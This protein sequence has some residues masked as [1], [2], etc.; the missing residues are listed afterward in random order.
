MENTNIIKRIPEEKKAE[1]FDKIAEMFFDKNFGTTT[2]SE[3]ELLMFSILMDEMIEKHKGEDNTLDYSA[4][5]DYKIGKMLG[6]TQEKVRSLKIKKQARYPVEFDWSKSLLSIKDNIVYDEPKKKII[7]PMPDPNLYNE[8]RNFVEEQGR[9][10]E[11]QRGQNCLQMRPEYLFMI[12]YYQIDDENK[13]AKVR[14]NFAKELRK[15]NEETSIESIRTDRELEEA[16]RLQTESNVENLL[17]VFQSILED[18][19]P[20][21]KPLL[22]AIRAIGKAWRNGRHMT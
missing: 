6:I 13:K 1:Y 21:G 2:K 12:L 15:R 14:E 10:I 3:I 9:Y 22:S 5:S 20:L 7:I 18:I 4:C 8:I 16:A 17:D 11:I 19:S